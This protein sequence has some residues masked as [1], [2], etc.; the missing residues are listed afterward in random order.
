[1]GQSGLIGYA[2]TSEAVGIAQGPSAK[3]Y[4]CNSNEVSVG[5]SAV[6]TVIGRASTPDYR[7][8]TAG[9]FSRGVSAGGSAVGRQGGSYEG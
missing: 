1:M 8:T 2:R 4:A 6:A 9:A 5:V 3:G 7:G